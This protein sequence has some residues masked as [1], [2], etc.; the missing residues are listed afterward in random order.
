MKSTK[1]DKLGKLQKALSVTYAESA[2]GEV[3]ELWSVRV[4]GH[5]KS[6]PAIYPGSG[7]LENLQQLVWRLSPVAIALVLLLSAAVLQ[8]DF[9]SDYELAEMFVE[10]PIELSLL[11]EYTI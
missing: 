10:D 7:F 8:S 4:M 2:K 9:T 5:I 1:E 3:G 6:L 11:G